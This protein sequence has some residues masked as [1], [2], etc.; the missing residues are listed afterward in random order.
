VKVGDLVEYGP[1]LG[2][3]WKKKHAGVVIEVGAFIR[4]IFPSE[5]EERPSWYH[6]DNLEVISESKT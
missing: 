6:R 1:N 2:P 4:V 3:Q 5:R